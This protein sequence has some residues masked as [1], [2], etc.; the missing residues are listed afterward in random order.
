MVIGAFAA[1]AHEPELQR[2]RER[3]LIERE[4]WSLEEEIC[5]A[6]S[7]RSDAAQVPG[8]TQDHLQVFNI[9]TKAKMK[10]HQMKEQVWICPWFRIRYDQG[11]KLLLWQRCG[12]MQAKWP[13]SVNWTWSTSGNVVGWCRPNGQLRSIGS[14]P[15]SRVMTLPGCSNHDFMWLWQPPR[16]RCCGC[17]AWCGLQFKSLDLTL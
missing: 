1:I 4:C 2:E 12:L 10:S 5:Y 11:F 8:T 3:D 6:A 17:I 15:Q 7:A 9:E 13:I 14:D 16:P